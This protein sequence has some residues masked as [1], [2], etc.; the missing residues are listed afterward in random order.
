MIEELYDT[1]RPLTRG[2]NVSD[3]QLK[4]LIALQAM[5]ADRPRRRVE[6]ILVAHVVTNA[7]KTDVQRANG[8]AFI[9]RCRAFES[10]IANLR[11]VYD[12]YT[13]IHACRDYLDELEVG[14]SG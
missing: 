1:L 4:S 2:M 8:R 11:S 5:K 12:Y 3:A 14:F 10:P 9:E 13:T 6:M 7:C